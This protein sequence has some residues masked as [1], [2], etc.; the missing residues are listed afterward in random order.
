M[1]RPDCRVRV[2][3]CPGNERWLT[4]PEMGA[5][6]VRVLEKIAA[7]PGDRQSAL[8]ALESVRLKAVSPAVAR[9]IVEARGRLTGQ[10][11]QLPQ[12]DLDHGRRNGQ[13]FSLHR[14]WS[15]SS[16]M[17]CWTSS[18]SLARP[19]EG[20]GAMAPSSEV[21]GRV[22][23]FAA[24]ATTVGWPTHTAP[25]R[26]GHDGRLQPPADEGRL[27]LTMEALVLRPEY[28]ELS[29]SMKDR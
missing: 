17:T 4:D 19:P 25:R 16:T 24:S 13:A 2:P 23:S 27:E 28:A 21:I 11:P 29:R 8:S 22:T 7:R 6:A 26:R 18:G 1:A 5:F 9:D 10:G 14:P 12:V 3:G 15:G 20:R